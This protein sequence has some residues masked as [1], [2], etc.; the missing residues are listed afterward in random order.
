MKKT[1]Y[2][3]VFCVCCGYSLAQVTPGVSPLVISAPPADSTGFYYAGGR[4][5]MAARA[6]K[7]DEPTIA[8]AVFI[9]GINQYFQISNDLSFDQVSSN[10]DRL[11]MRHVHLQQYF[12]GMPLEGL[13]Y[14]VH[15]RAGLVT[16]VNGKAVRH[17]QLDVG[18][19]LSESEAFQL[20]IAHLET[21]DTTERSGRKLIVSRDFSYAPGSF[22]VA[23]QFDIDVSLVERWRISIDARD[24]AVVNKVSLVKN[25]FEPQD[26]GYQRGTGLTNY[27]GRVS[28]PVLKYEDGSSRLT[29]HT[30]NGGNITTMDFRN[31]SLIALIFGARAYHFYS[32]D[33]TYDNAYHNPAVSVQWAAEQTYEYYFQK[34]G[35][36]SFND[37][38][39]EITS[40]VHVEEGWDNAAWTGRIMV[41]G[42]GSNNNALVELDVVSHEL[43]H[44]VTDYE[45]ELI[46]SYEPGALNES[47]SDIMAK[48]VEFGSFGDTATWYLA[49][50]FRDGGL[51]DMRNPNLK[52]QPDT[53]MG[54]MWY[55]GNAD[56]GGI[57]TNS[58]V[59]NYWYYLLCEGGSGVN[60]RGIGYAVNAIGMD[61][62]TDIAYRNLTEY[63]IPSSDHLDSRIGSLLSAADLYGEN[64]AEYLE[65]EKAWDAVGVIDEPI[66]TNFRLYD[67]TATS[68]KFSGQLLDRG[69][70]MTHHVQYD[71]DSSYGDSTEIQAYNGSIE[72]IVTGLQ[73]E[74]KYYF[75]L[76]AGNE[77][78]N[79]YSYSEATTF[80]LAPLVIIETTIDVSDTSAMLYG[81]INPNSLPTSYYFRYGPT[82]EMDLQTA[83]YTLPDTVEYLDIAVEVHDL[84]PRQTYF[85]QLV[86]S[87]DFSTVISDTL[88]FYS[89]TKPVIDAIHPLIAEIGDEITISGHHFNA[90]PDKNRVRFGAT[91]GRVI[92]ASAEEIKVHVPAGASY[93]PI[94]IMDAESGLSD[95]S[96]QEF[97]PTFSGAFES[98]SFQLRAGFNDFSV[99]QFWVNDIDGDG[100]PD[101]I[102][103]HNDGFS[104]YQNLSK[105][106]D[107]SNESFPLSNFPMPDFRMR[108]LTDFDGDGRDDIVGYF[109][110]K[111]RVIPNLSIPGYLFLGVPADILTINGTG[112]LFCL[113]FDDDGYKD[114]LEMRYESYDSTALS[115]FRN[116][117]PKGM[118]CSEKFELQWY[119]MAPYF[120]LHSSHIISDLN[121]DGK[122]DLIYSGSSSDSLK[123]LWNRSRRGS[124]QFEEFAAKH[125]GLVRSDSYIGNDLNDDGWKDIV[126]FNFDGRK[127]SVIENKEA[128]IEVAEMTAVGEGY[129]INSLYPGDLNGDGHVDILAGNIY[130]GGFAFL[131]NRMDSVAKFSNTSFEWSDEYGINFGIDYA[132]RSFAVLNDMNG[133]GRPEVISNVQKSSDD[134]AGYRLEIWQNAPSDCLDPSNLTVLVASKTASI[135]LPDNTNVGQYELA[136]ALEGS[137]EWKS[138]F[139][140]GLSNLELGAS[141]VLRAR[142]TCYLGYTPFHYINFATPCVDLESFAVTEIGLNWLKLTATDLYDFEVQYSEADN[143]QWE[144]LAENNDHIY[145][146]DLGTTYDL[147]YRGRCLQPNQ[148]TYLQFTTRC[149]EL[150]A[151]DVQ[152]L[153]YNRANV[154]WSSQY[155][156]V[157]IIEY[158]EDSLHWNGVDESGVIFPLVPG[159]KYH[160]R[161]ALQCESIHSPFITASF[162]TPCPQVS[163]LTVSKITP[164]SAQARWADESATGSYSITLTSNDGMQATMQASETTFDFENLRPGVEYQISVAPICLGGERQSTA[165]FITI[166]NKPFGL[167]A[168]EI[169]YTSAQLSWED[170]LGHYPYSI[171]YSIVGSGEWQAIHA[172]LA[173]ISLP[174]LRPGTKYE[175]RV[176]VACPTAEAQSAPIQFITNLY[177]KT[178]IAPNPTNDAITLYPSKHLIGNQFRIYDDT[179]RT[180]MEGKVLGYTFD[181]AA[182]KAGVYIL[183]IDQEQAMKIMK[184]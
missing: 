125:S 152:N 36:N 111:L 184:E 92:A 79:S 21:K 69:A 46:Y 168:D 141:Y 42:D 153:T 74:T 176:H 26:E 48:A 16:S 144:T 10:T 134:M 86:A 28:I 78:G 103:T 51:R 91:E 139:S 164:T 110:G 83:T 160:L 96:V 131:K 63:L 169:T 173:S 70:E 102:A 64:S 40:Y 149:P 76:V 126:V 65:V 94:S 138:T 20:A 179:G 123:V 147:R 57:H 174:N 177:D 150:A 167:A 82:P 68:V 62:A 35:R 113:D 87:N 24:G 128:N 7:Y 124:M 53:Y 159:K 117:N 41:F 45:A 39:A 114:I 108:A 31:N 67:V 170:S 109:Q 143:N 156:Q 135:Q 136:Y 38:G 75:R 14:R 8:T 132:L 158:S 77:H 55:E 73:S 54:E 146:L 17:I 129:A 25:C 18:T 175:A 116:K 157:P 133:D 52:D 19:L 49:K 137:Q 105:D 161:G 15:E 90:N 145:N 66:I 58:G 162:V 60:D 71:R 27:Y 9:A 166:C 104:I 148:F 43:T 30:K 50:Y 44:G 142:A 56:Y 95:E 165:R 180:M 181:L 80:S 120:L 34:H 88:S 3:L 151:L 13:G 130:N 23:Y 11:G 33:T 32:D 182:L 99:S 93:G 61:A 5:N 119:K 154:T 118:L 106:K 2:T 47:F 163:M 12:D 140:T 1:F 121:N 81:S 112:S 122:P 72:G 4:E 98:G 127:T 97:V 172:A 37:E 171:H 178:T 183:K 84:L 100:S 22:S 107:I 89:A 115:I 6:I 85:Y 59:Q 29:G 101:I 155:S